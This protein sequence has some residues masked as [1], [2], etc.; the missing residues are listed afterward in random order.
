MIA[1]DSEFI[2][3]GKESQLGDYPFTALIR[4][5]ALDNVLIE[6]SKCIFRIFRKYFRNLTIGGTAGVT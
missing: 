3:G 5:E 6:Y 4:M 2:F 1:A